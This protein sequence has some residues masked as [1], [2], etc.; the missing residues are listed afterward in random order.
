MS[1]W[2]GFRP[3]PGEGTQVGDPEV[4]LPTHWKGC[5]LGLE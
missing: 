5:G 1:L 3:L 2:L 4:G